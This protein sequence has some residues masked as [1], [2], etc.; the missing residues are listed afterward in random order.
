M[1]VIEHLERAKGPLIS[2]EII[3]PLRGGN[4]QELLALIEDLVEHRPPFIDITSHAA[5]AIFEE[6]AQGFQRRVKRKRPGTLGVCA[7]IQNKWGVDAVPHILC[8]GFTREETEDFLIEL[9]YLGIDNV[10]AVRGDD[11]GYEKPLQF[12]RSANLYALDLVQQ[13]ADMNRGKYLERDLLDAAPARFSIGVAGYPEKHFEA[14]NLLTDIRRT[15]EKIDAGADYV[16]TQMF[17]DNRLFFD[18][19]DRCREQGIEAPIIP[20]IKILSSRKQLMTIPRVFHVDIPDALSLEVEN[21]PAERAEDV[22]V[23]WA[24]AQSRALLERGVPAIHFYVMQSSQA[25]QKVLKTL[26]VEPAL[27]AARH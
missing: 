13:I 19:V 7:L 14:P 18:Y 1:K 3:P 16:V 12:G 5:E 8:R 24:L 22:G 15:K 11:S 23:E 4:V 21:Q 26:E 6:T 2:F 10:L 9:R 17:F 20:G 27:A 25:I